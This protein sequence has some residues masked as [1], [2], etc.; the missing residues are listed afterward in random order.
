[1]DML[2]KLSLVGFVVL[3]GRGSVAQVAFGNMLSFAFFAAHM[4]CFP[5]KTKWDNWLRA[6]AEIHVFWTITIAFV[7]RNDLS[8]ELLDEDAWGIILVA[9]LVICVPVSYLVT[10]T[11]KLREISRDLVAAQQ[12]VRLT[13]RNV[14][15][16]E[17]DKLVSSARL[18]Y[19]YYKHGLA[20]AEDRQLLRNYCMELKKPEA[21]RSTRSIS[22]NLPATP[23]PT[24]G[25]LAGGG[26][27]DSEFTSWPPARHGLQQPPPLRRRDDKSRPASPDE[28]PASRQHLLS[29]TGQSQSDA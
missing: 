28:Q 25:S 5:M 16:T 2:R 19:C 9:S 13:R 21:S 1:M 10:I 22:H 29:G 3:V 24:T 4:Y 15:S 7:V 18:A 20:T 26:A 27:A 6:A 14:Q 12:D 11:G 23:H 8:H 17:N